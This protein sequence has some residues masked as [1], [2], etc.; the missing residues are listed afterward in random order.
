MSLDQYSI[1]GLG[2]GRLEALTDGIFATVMTVLVLSL[3]VPVIASNIAGSQLS[4]EVVVDIEALWPNI[5]GLR[6]QFLA[7]SCSLDKSP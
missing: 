1:P 7:V 5:L 4:S 3:S 2:K 6:S